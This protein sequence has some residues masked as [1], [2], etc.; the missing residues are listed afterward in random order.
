MTDQEDSVWPNSPPEVGERAELS[1][2]VEEEDIEKFSEISGDFNPLHYDEEA[3]QHSGFG[4]IVVQGGITTA[5]LNGVVAEK[6]PGPGTVF[7]NVNWDFEAPVRPDD[8]ITGIVEV[9]DVREDKPIAEL[10]TKIVRQDDVVVLEGSAVCYQM[11]VNYDS[12]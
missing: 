8:R 5:V 12:D 4:E 9:I 2:T 7:L 11:D 10:D 3:A 1:R 6:L